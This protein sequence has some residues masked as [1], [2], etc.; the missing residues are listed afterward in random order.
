MEELTADK[1]EEILQNLLPAMDTMEVISGRWR[2]IILTNLYVHGKMRFNELKKHIPRITSRILSKD[3]KFLENHQVISRT[4]K[5]TSPMTVEYELTD[6]GRTM[7][8]IFHELSGWGSKHRKRI[9][10]K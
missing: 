10:G 8:N 6:Y 2:V 3:L 5:D 7:E 4:V 9:I 1:K